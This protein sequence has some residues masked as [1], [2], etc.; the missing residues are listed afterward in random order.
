MY[1]YEKYFI[2][3]IEQVNGKYAKSKT[4]F[5]IS[6]CDGKSADILGQHAGAN[7]AFNKIIE[8]KMKLLSGFFEINEIKNE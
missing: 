2:E 1:F 7:V 3:M 5:K 8:C 6:N 4:K